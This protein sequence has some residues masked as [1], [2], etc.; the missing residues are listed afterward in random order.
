[1]N[2]F[3][4]EFGREETQTRTLFGAFS[5]L[6]RAMAAWNERA[7]HS[8]WTLYVVQVEIDKVQIWNI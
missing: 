8:N 6:Q 5:S 4:A 1:M 7:D 3:V 2:V